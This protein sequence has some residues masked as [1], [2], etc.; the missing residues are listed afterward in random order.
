M[1]ALEGTGEPIPISLVAHYA[2]C[3]RRAWL[4]AMG[5]RADSYQMV[6]GEVEHRRS[7]DPKASRPARLRAL[8]VGSTR[9][10]IVGRC[11]SVEIDDQGQATVVEFK[12]T[13]VRRRASV[14]FPMV[15]QL[16]LEAEALREA[17]REVV[18]AAVYFS[19]HE[20]R[21][22][23]SLDD[24]SLDA[25]L[26][27]L[28]ACRRMLAESDAPAPFEDDPRCSR[29]SHVGICLPD[30]RRLG[31]VARRIVVADPDSQVVH[32][33]TPGSRA[34]LGGGRLRVHHRGEEVASVPIERVLG[35]VVHGNVDLSSALVRE[36][37]WRRLS[38][39]WCSGSGRVIGWAQT[40]ETP[41]GGSRVAQNV[42]SA[43]GHLDLARRFVAAKI[44]NQ[45]TILRRG[46][47]V[48]EGV[49][50]L[51]ALQRSALGAE[52]IADVYGSEGEAASVYFSSFHTLVKPALTNVSVKWAR[53]RRP[54]RD[55]LNAALNYAYGLLLADAIR[56]V[57]AAGLDPHA[58]F[59][60]SS[61]RNKPAL[62]LDLCEELRAPVAD[63]VVIGAFNN[64]EL[65][66]ADF[67][68]IEGAVRLRDRGRVALVEAYE[69]R[70]TTRFKHP[71]F[72]YEV[73]WRRAME[74]QARLV[75]GVVEGT[76]Q[77]YQG[78]VVR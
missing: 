61:G 49:R 65:R 37:L 19:S 53:T 46:A 33:A 73:T 27:E 14:T 78:I 28:A 45:A 32:L 76:V 10:G 67:A 36:L 12:A 44:A 25:A 51:R 70:V 74:V 69:R 24:S 26:S 38:L 71:V 59:L 13:P 4:E 30:E 8:D 43:H 15:V 55:P 9:L 11:D 39:V 64:G 54:A 52:S 1:G 3:P 20:K 29:C 18:G 16:A 62:A 31:P 47:G 58:G 41:N 66:D 2:F 50:R 68:T 42:M 56:A 77:R 60:H 72:A 48:T 75:L 21:V 17:G 34:S 63:S 22:P 57:V 40:A 35:L 23:V 5:E 6:I 7:D